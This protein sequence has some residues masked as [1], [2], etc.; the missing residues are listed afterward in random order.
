LLEDIFVYLQCKAAHNERWL[1]LLKVRVDLSVTQY[2]TESGALTLDPTE[3]P[4]DYPPVYPHDPIEEIQSDVFMVR[5]CINL[6]ALMTISRNMTIIRHDG[7]LTL[8]DPIR[9]SS[10]E[11]SR[12]ETLGSVKRILRLGPMH[13]VDDP[14]Y[15]ERYKAELWA[16][17]PSE[18]HPEPSADV[19]FDA[20]TP[21]P[22]PDATMFCFAGLKQ[23]EAALLLQRGPGLLITCDSIQNYGD[24]RH[25]N[26]AARLIM[27]LIGFR[28]TTLIGPIWAKRMP[29][30]GISVESEFRRLLELDFD[31]LISAHGSFLSSG[32]HEACRRAVDKQ[33]SG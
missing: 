21:L 30:E 2:L 4:M 26:L 28:K 5:G 15:I 6:N 24:F 19:Q 27:P 18:A 25:N 1:L 10:D 31:Q 11:E 32:A 17:G 9:L 12:L 23:N 14:Y 29:V 22:F 3:N 20:S 8:V 13:G 7:E 16:P 33:F